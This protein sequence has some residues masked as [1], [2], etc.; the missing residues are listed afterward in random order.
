[1]IKSYTIRLSSSPFSCKLAKDS[2]D[3]AL[4]FGLD[5]HYFDAINKTNVDEFFKKN[6]L[7]PKDYPAM[8]VIGTRGC[9][10]SHY[11]LWQICVELG[12]SIVI[13][14][15]DGLLI[16]DVKNIVKKTEGVCHLDPY[17][18]FYDSYD[19]FVN[20]YSGED[21][22]SYSKKHVKNNGISNSVKEVKPPHFN[23]T[24]GY[25]ITPK[26]AEALVNH[27]KSNECVASDESIHMNIVKLQRTLSTHIRIHPFFKNK[28]M[29]A[30]FST[31]KRD[32]DISNIF[33]SI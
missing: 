6:G 31:R 4:N 1:M 26:S 18:P 32:I 5:A 10:A 9:F 25:V 17:S 29:V 27:Y 30:N 12:E 7:I 33:N 14:E 21:V 28:D 11:N 19:R 16:K 13:M 15:H 2:Y 22:I 8:K 24:Y 20:L 23:G 3:S